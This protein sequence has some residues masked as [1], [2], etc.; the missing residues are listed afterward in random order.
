MFAVLIYTSRSAA[1]HVLTRLPDS[2]A[3][4]PLSQGL[5]QLLASTHERKYQDVYRRAEDLHQYVSQPAFSEAELGQ[6]MA[7]MA[8]SFIGQYRD[9]GM[10]R[11]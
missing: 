5:F 7:G 2:L 1:R 4:Y 11:L 8:T 9:A 10:I 6:I 3:A